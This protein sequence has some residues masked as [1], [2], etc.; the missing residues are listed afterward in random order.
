[1]AVAYQSVDGNAR[2]LGVDP[3]P[4][5]PAGTVNTDLLLAVGCSS[6]SAITP[7]DAS[8]IEHGSSLGS[9]FPL[10]T[11]IAGSSEPAS[12]NFVTA[13][14][15]SSE[16]VIV[17]ITGHDLTSPI[18]V[19]TGVAGTGSLVI[20]TMSPT[21]GRTVFQIALKLG[22]TS[23][24]SP[25]TVTERFDQTFSSSNFTGAGGDEIAPGGAMGT[26]TWTPAAGASQGV[27][28]SIAIKSAIA[29]TV[30]S[31]SGLSTVTGIGVTIISTT[32]TASG[33]GS[34]AGNGAS[35]IGLTGT[36]SGSSTASASSSSVAGTVGSATGTSSVVA[37]ASKILGTIGSILGLSTASG[38]G[39]ATST[40]TGS[41]SGTSTASGVLR[42]GA[43]T[44]GTT[45]GSST[46]SGSAGTV[47]QTTGNALGHADA[48]G[49]TG[50]VVSGTGTCTIGGGDVTVK[51][52][53]VFD[54]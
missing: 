37:L 26:R 47:A 13:G 53:F 29:E 20:P 17:R 39:A 5:K 21:A 41:T 8:W 19:V 54:D 10:W 45:S 30:G 34:V 1:M 6:S 36:A 40:A 52:I 27:A 51:P 48:T 32:G 46:A 43:G 38:V 28:Y 12:Y 11:K 9:Q 18:E 4:P 49:I 7:P 23:F 24:T 16:V 25:G 42:A 22:S 15:S 3:T 14:T 50:I 35:R 2:N 44:T 33:S 31:A